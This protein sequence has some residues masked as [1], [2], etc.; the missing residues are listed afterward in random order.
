MFFQD[1]RELGVAIGLAA[2]DRN[3]A[4]SVCSFADLY[5]QWL[6]AFVRYQ[7]WICRNVGVVGKNSHIILIEIAIFRAQSKRIHAK[8]L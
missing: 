1:E 4:Q 7:A 2:F 8:W 3:E 6:S 5:F